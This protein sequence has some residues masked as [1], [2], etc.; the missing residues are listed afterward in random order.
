MDDPLYR[1]RSPHLVSP[2]KDGQIVTDDLDITIEDFLQMAGPEVTEPINKMLSTMIEDGADIF[3]IA[4][5]SDAL[6][7][8]TNLLFVAVLDEGREADSAD[9]MTAEM[10]GMCEG[11]TRAVI[12][13]NRF[14]AY[15]AAVQLLPESGPEDDDA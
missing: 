2:R 11:I 13:I 1:G 12:V 4:S 8:L 5:T 7:R 10:L 3:E 9:E 6:E 15:H 14:M